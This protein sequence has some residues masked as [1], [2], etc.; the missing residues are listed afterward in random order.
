MM[1]MPPEI[2]P[3]RNVGTLAMVRMLLMILNIS[4]PRNVPI[5]LPR[6]PLMDVP[7]MATAAMASI[8]KRLPALAEAT[9]ITREA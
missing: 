7:P 5:I 6:P 3:F 9:A 8:S 1:M 4:T 2:A